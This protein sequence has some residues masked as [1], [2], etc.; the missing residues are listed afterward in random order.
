MPDS[1]RRDDGS[2]VGAA[3]GHPA[4]RAGASTYA[5]AAGAGERLD[6]MLAEFGTLLHRAVSRYLPRGLG[7]D[8]S[9]IEQD[10]RVRIWNAL[11]RESEVRNAA[12]YLYTVAAA[13]TIDAIRRVKARREV[14]LDALDDVSCGVMTVP[15]EAVPVDRAVADLEIRGIVQDACA[16]LSPN[17]KQAVLLHL[18]GFTSAEIA[19]I[20]GWTEAKARNLASRGMKDLRRELGRMGFDVE[21]D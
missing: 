12:S 14:S 10:A 1:R 20:A 18:R 11:R 4:L 2:T 19:T 17:R 5:V 13:A 7:L 9:E 21:A 8:A 3:A 15:V 16:K 6:S